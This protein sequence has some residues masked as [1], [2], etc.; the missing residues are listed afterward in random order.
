MRDL[1]TIYSRPTHRHLT[2]VPEAERSG[3]PPASDGQRVILKRRRI[4]RM[5]IYPPLIAAAFVVSQ[6][7]G[8]NVPLEALPRPLLTA[9]VATVCLQVCLSL[10]LASLDRGAYVSLLIALLFTGLI[11]I[12]LLLVAWVSAAAV[13]S[14]ARGRGIR[15]MPWFRATRILNTVAILTLAVS[16]FNAG[17]SGALSF[18]GVGWNVPRGAAAADAPDIYLIM[19]DGYPRADTI[20]TRLGMDNQ[21]FLNSMESLGFEV[22]ERSHSNYDVTVLTLASLFNGE[23]IPSL[24]PDPPTAVPDQFRMVSKLINQGERLEQFRRAGYEL[25]TIPSGYPEGTLYS[26]DRVI[27]SGELSSYETQLLMSGGAP[28]LMGGIARGWLPDEH[29]SRIRHSFEALGRLAA[30]RDGPPKFVFTHVMSPHTP[31]VFTKDGHAAEPFPCFPVSCGLFS[32]GDEYG[33]LK[34]GP[35]A[36]QIRWLN[37]AVEDTVRTIQTRSERP[38][39]IVIFSDHGMRYWPDDRDEMLRSLFLAVTPGRPG[40]FPKDTTPVN[41]LAR[42]LNSYTGTAIALSSEESRWIDTR[43]ADQDGLF[44]FEARIVDRDVPPPQ[45]AVPAA[46]N[47]ENGSRSSDPS[48]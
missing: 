29:R 8:F 37:S 47:H 21:P 23:Q 3:D 26:A 18:S 41:I 39:V 16:I 7:I 5:P 44:Q 20:A 28:Q 31:I 32:Y 24:I 9:V 48:Q 38:P 13:V 25:V 35:L 4:S 43:F 11:P 17:L 22:A 14:L 2:I 1:G 40:L 27:D 19:L 12:E 46:A 36:D 33:D 45:P 6:F 30:E 42:L 15:T 10:I 34:I